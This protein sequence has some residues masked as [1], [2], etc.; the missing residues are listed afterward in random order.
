MECAE[1]LAK[2]KMFGYAIS[3][4][5]LAIEELI[6]YQVIMT[7][8]VNKYPFDDVIEPPKGKSVFN[9]HTTRGRLTKR[10]S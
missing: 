6:K 2:N 1:I 9:D 7:R 8:S 5:I 10:K 4:L 3:H